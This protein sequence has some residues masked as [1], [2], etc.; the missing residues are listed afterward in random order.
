MTD[1]AEITGAVGE[2]LF[3]MDGGNKGEL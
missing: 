3:A 2:A 1:N